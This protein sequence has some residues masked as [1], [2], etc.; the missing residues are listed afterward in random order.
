[1]VG[2]W[3]GK[4]GHGNLLNCTCLGDQG[5]HTPVKV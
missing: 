5:I 2:E 3:A 1:M 4:G